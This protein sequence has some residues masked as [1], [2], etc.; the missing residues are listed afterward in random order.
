MR[1]YL[2]RIEQ[3]TGD[4]ESKNREL[5]SYKLEIQRLQRCNRIQHETEQLSELVDQENGKSINSFFEP[6]SRN[7]WKSRHMSLTASPENSAGRKVLEG[8]NESRKVAT[9]DFLSPFSVTR[10]VEAPDNRH[11]LPSPLKDTHP[12]LL[13]FTVPSGGFQQYQQVVVRPA[14]SPTPVSGAIINPYS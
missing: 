14:A 10:M 1:N 13:S 9:E 6:N 2:E 3:L 11:K 12:N 5:Q 8:I 4:L 7:E